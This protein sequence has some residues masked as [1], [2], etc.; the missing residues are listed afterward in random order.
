MSKGSKKADFYRRLI[1][2]QRKYKRRNR[3]K[4]S[5]KLYNLKRA[6]NTKTVQIWAFP[7]DFL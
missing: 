1:N 7:K 4:N 5:E 3:Q 2:Q 6:S